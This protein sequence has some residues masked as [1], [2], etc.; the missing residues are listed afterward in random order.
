MYPAKKDATHT[1]T[2]FQVDRIAFF[3][4]AV[5][6]IAI[7]LLVLEIKIPPLGKEA[8]WEQIVQQFGHTLFIE[9]ISLCVCFASIGNLWIRHHELY[10]HINNYSKQ[11]VKI[12]LYFLL[13][14]ILLP[15]SISFCFEDNNPISLRFS[16]LCIN[17][18]LCNFMFYLMQLIVF[19][20]KNQFSAL[21]TKN[22]MSL[23]KKHSLV[24]ACVLLVAGLLALWGVSWF[25]LLIF[26]FPL[27]RT[28][29]KLFNIKSFE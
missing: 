19:H 25:Y 17:L 4:D 24:H 18:A 16:V 6:A 12:N 20:K 21:N 22:E 3:S 15:L 27:I 9:F 11:L 13:T 1:R 8:T 5:I 10:E 14:I 29:S 2:Q 26:V 23:Q 28:V 7:T